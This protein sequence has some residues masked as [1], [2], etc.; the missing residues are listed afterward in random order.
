MTRISFAWAM[1][2]E[3]PQDPLDITKL[4]DQVDLAQKLGHDILGLLRSMPP[5]DRE[6]SRDEDECEWLWTCLALTHPASPF[7]DAGFVGADCP[8]VDPNDKVK[9]LRPRDAQ[10]WAAFVEAV[11]ERYDGDGIDDMPGLTRPVRVWQVGAEY[12]RVWCTNQDAMGADFAGFMEE[13]RARVMKADP[14]AT[15]KMTGL[16]SEGVRTLAFVDGEIEGDTLFVKGREVTREDVTTMTGYEAL[17]ESIETPLRAGH[18]DAADIHLYGGLEEIP[19]RVAWVQGIAGDV[20][21]WA[22]EGGGPFAGA[23]ADFDSGCVDGMEYG[24]FVETDEHLER[25]AAYVVGYYL[26]GLAAGVAVLAWHLPSEYEQWGCAFGD[27]NLLDAAGDPRPAYHAYSLLTEILQ[28]YDQVEREAVDE[29]AR[30]LHVT[31]ED[32]SRQIHVL[33]SAGGETTVDLSARIDGSVQIYRLPAARGETGKVPV[34][35]QPSGLT[36]GRVPVFVETEES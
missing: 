22:G 24:D 7:Y 20:P 19:A 5:I 26:T 34:D 23:D 29:P 32:S 4:D 12:P 14:G 8:P 2:Q 11:V 21:V 30:L 27:L 18:F 31:F 16:V 6:V 13:T 10:G 15:F 25:Q 35:M 3:A 17:R 33:W 28:G 36:V 9:I 1:V